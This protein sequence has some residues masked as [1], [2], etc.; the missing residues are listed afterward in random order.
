MY[1]H[2]FVLALS[3]EIYDLGEYWCYILSWI[4]VYVKLEIGNTMLRVFERCFYILSNSC[5]SIYILGTK[6]LKVHS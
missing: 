4:I 1:K 2:V 5:H 3:D 6:I